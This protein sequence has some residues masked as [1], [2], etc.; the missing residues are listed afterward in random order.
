MDLRADGSV[1]YRKGPDL[2]EYDA[3]DWQVSDDKLC[4]TSKNEEHKRRPSRFCYSAV[5]DGTHLRLF[6][7]AGL[8]QSDATLARASA[9]AN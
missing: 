2:A 1:S 3:G 4:R 9:A 6:D 7:G 8:M 5:L